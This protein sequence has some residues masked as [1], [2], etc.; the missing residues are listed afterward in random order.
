MN[1][2]K[3]ECHLKSF[4]GGPRSNSF[5]LVGE[6]SGIYAYSSPRCPRFGSLHRRKCKV[7]V[8]SCRKFKVDPIDR[9]ELIRTAIRKTKLTLVMIVIS[10]IFISPRQ[11]DQSQHCIPQSA[12]TAAFAVSSRLWKYSPIVACPK[13]RVFH[14]RNP[15]SLHGFPC[16]TD[17]S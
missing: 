17:E 14:S 12:R 16:H 4:F 8:K 15:E 6:H 11:P 13:R 9:H 3:K 5:P 1:K 2:K 7:E 10:E